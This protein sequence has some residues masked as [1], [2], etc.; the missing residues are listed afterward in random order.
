M[1]TSSSIGER[2]GD[3]F[4][5]RI[6]DL[7]KQIDTLNQDP[8]AFS[9]AALNKLFYKVKTTFHTIYIKKPGSS[10]QAERNPLAAGLLRD[11]EVLTR[12]TGGKLLITD[13][14]DSALHRI[15]R[16]EDSYYLLVYSPLNSSKLGTIKITTT[17]Q[18]YRIVYDNNQ[19]ADYISDYI[20]K[21]QGES[22]EIKL[23]NLAFQKK[24]LSFQVRDFFL[25][26]EK[27]STGRI[28]IK[29]LIKNSANRA[30][31]SKSRIITGKKSSVNISI[32]FSW[33]KK[34]RYYIILEAADLYTQ[35]STMELLETRIQ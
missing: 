35:K 16:T 28:Y 27:N 22:L 30:V 6:R 18:D 14:I 24:S 9:S 10:D 32:D 17:S 25:N 1:F 26:R 29:I 4:I 23:K 2:E 5:T 19:R 21:K 33:L 12:D 3:V 34:D 20:K 13:T 11:L 7:F 31:Y 15:A 8:S